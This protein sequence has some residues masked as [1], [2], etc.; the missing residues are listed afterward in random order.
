MVKPQPPK[1]KILRVVSGGQTG[2]EGIGIP[3][4]PRMES[5]HAASHFLPLF[6]PSSSVNDI[7]TRG[8]QVLASIKKHLQWQNQP[9]A[10]VATFVNLFGIDRNNF[11]IDALVQAQ[12]LQ[13]LLNVIS[14]PLKD[15]GLVDVLEKAHVHCVPAKITA[16]PVADSDEHGICGGHLVEA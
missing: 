2:A 4:N 15:D 10:Q 9:A 16:F 1:L 7:S 6:S 12:I 8:A 11:K 3:T 5:S 13:L 14:V